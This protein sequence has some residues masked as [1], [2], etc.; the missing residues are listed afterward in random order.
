MYK[1]GKW[2]RQLI[3][4]QDEE[5]KW[6]W[7]HSLSKF[8]NAPVTTEQALRR[9]HRLGF[10]AQ[11][12]CIQRAL[13]YMADC[14]LRRKALPDRREKVMDWDVFTDLMLSTSIRLFE[15]QNAKANE[16]ANQWAQVVSAAFEGGCYDHQSYCRA[17][18][19]ILRPNGGRLV[20][21]ANYY[22][23]A[24]LNDSLDPSTQ[25]ALV[26]HILSEE[27]G[28]YYVYGGKLSR[29]PAVFQSRDA[30]NY[31]GAVELLAEYRYGVTELNF[32]AE[33]LLSQ[34][35]ESGRWDMGKSV[36][37]KLYFPLADDWRNL[38]SRKNDCTVRIERL[39]SKIG[40]LDC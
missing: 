16:V 34:R 21:L 33:W 38:E 14:L 25:I 1:D 13:F 11:D 30:S 24:L 10:T 3:A 9:L 4:M 7:F 40:V 15:K 27:N 35:D 26:S 37:D 31:L 17:Y 6:G 22:P 12:E 23:V 29:L 36:N 8:S 5:G 20:G 32:V 39:L 18:R 19:D 28:I 2:A